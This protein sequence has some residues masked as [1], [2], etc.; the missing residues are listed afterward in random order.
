MN[1]KADLLVESVPGILFYVLSHFNHVRLLASTCTVGRQL[2]LSVR[3]SS[4]EHWRG[5]ACPSPGALPNQGLNQCLLHLL[6]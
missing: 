2:P 1:K 6:H 5:L 3:F 4:Q